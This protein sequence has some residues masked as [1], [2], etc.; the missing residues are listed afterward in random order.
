MN[1]RMRNPNKSPEV[2]NVQKIKW[3][4]GAKRGPSP[5]SHAD[6]KWVWNTSIVGGHL[7][8]T[9]AGQAVNQRRIGVKG[10][11]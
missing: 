10:Y 1:Q 5:E 2:T 4:E 8:T 6:P 7:E 3:V 11:Q 9:V